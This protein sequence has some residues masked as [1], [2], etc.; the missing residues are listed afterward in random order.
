[1]TESKKRLKFGKYAYPTPK[2][3]R[4]LG[5]AIL[6]F[7]TTISTYAIAEEMKYMALASVLLGAIGKFLTN[8][9]SEEDV[10]SV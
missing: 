4:K 5:D 6:V 3:M 10:P 9:F 2:K 7:S 8:F 1:M